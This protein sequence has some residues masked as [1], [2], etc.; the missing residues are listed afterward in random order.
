PNPSNYA[1][2]SGRAGRDGQPALI[3]NF[4]GSGPGRGP[5]D[6]YFYRFPEKIISGM[7]RAPQ[8]LLDN[9]SL[10]KAHLNSFIL[11]IIDQ[12]LPT[13]NY[14][15]LDFEH[16]EELEIFPDIWNSLTN[17][18]QD[19]KEKIISKI[20]EA[21]SREMDQFDWFNESFVERTVDSFMLDLNRSYD[22]LRDEYR[23]LQGELTDIQRREKKGKLEKSD[24]RRRDAI[25][26]RLAAIRG[27]KRGDFYP[28][29][30]LATQGFL[31]NYA[32][33]RRSMTVT[34]SDRKDDMPRSDLRALHEMAPGNT[35]YLKGERY[36]IR[37]AR[38][39]RKDGELDYEPMK[40]CQECGQVF[41]GSERRSLSACP[42]CGTEFETTS[43]KAL[44]IP[45]MYATSRGRITAEEEERERRGY[46]IE[47]NYELDRRN[48]SWTVQQK[49]YE[50]ELQMDYESQGV[51]EKVNRGVR[52][53]DPAESPSGF[54]LCTRCN[55]WLM[56]DDSLHKHLDEDSNKT[57]SEG[58]NLEDVVRGLV[59]YSESKCDVISIV[60]KPGVDL[61]EGKLESFYWSLAYTIKN[62][63]TFE[64]DLE[65]G[66]LDVFVKE[67][68]DQKRIVLYESVE[69][70]LGVLKDLKSPG[71]LRAVIERG[72]ELLHYEE[73]EEEACE[74]AC[75]DCLLSFYNQRYHSLM[76]RRLVIPYLESL[77]EVSDEKTLSL[78]QEKGWEDYSVDTD[79]DFEVDVL[80]IMQEVNLPP[81]DEDHKTIYDEGTP[82]LEAD[83]YYKPRTI[84]MVD[85][86][87]HYKKYVRKSDQVKRRIVK[88]LRYEVVELTGSKEEMIEKLE[89]VRE[90]IS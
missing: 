63:T 31:P 19:H 41:I 52:P 37:Y 80:E 44:R 20:K 29:K 15:I 32:F 2:R 60:A 45:D 72:L 25:Y 17:S 47:D 68:G 30:Y 28:F 40:E 78:E 81:P 5:H 55:K 42:S 69:G 54:H 57:C 61:E 26:S 16:L 73:S 84:I 23:R 1:Q 56:S 88:G 33:P 75:Y 10:V 3:L 4:C 85:G 12:K 89:S 76:N 11:E 43:G 35:V 67:Q 62:A 59:L 90:R 48:I 36:M 34:F 39:P 86:S 8:F 82:I 46:I 71:A 14:E 38:P 79:S 7:I 6:Q 64:F 18:I 13:K 24:K 51:V 9:K 77:K 87:P 58:A 27:E 53:K 74:K 83:F 21:F 66:E 70:G 65:E 49:D 22:W 50:F